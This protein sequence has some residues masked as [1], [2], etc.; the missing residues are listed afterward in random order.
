MIFIQVIKSFVDNYNPK[1]Q[2]KPTRLFSGWFG[3]VLHFNRI[4][5]NFKT[6]KLVVAVRID[7]TW[8]NRLTQPDYTPNLHNINDD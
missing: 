2:L 3:L 1:N 5:L 8:K 6:K 7:S 4:G